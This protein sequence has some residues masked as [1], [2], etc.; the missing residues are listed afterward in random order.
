[1]KPITGTAQA[2][3]ELGAQAAPMKSVKSLI[4]Q[5]E[6]KSGK[7]AV[8][9]ASTGKASQSLAN[10]ESLK[11]VEEALLPPLPKTKPLVPIKKSTLA[12]AKETPSLFGSEASRLEAE[13]FSKAGG[14][15]FLGR[16]EISSIG[17]Q[18]KVPAGMGERPLA[19]TAKMGESRALEALNLEVSQSSS[20]D[21]LARFEQRH[22]KTA[23]QNMST[24]EFSQSL[25]NRADRKF[26]GNGPEVGKQ[27]HKYAKKLGERY[28]E[29]TGDKEHLMFEKR[30]IRNKKWE[31]GEGLKGSVVPDVYDPVT[32]EVFDYK[33][34]K[35]HLGTRQITNTTAVM[36]QLEG[37]TLAM[38]EVKPILKTE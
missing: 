13:F 15:S 29:M 3:E 1:M 26:L 38:T 9:N 37:K 36:P 30:F 27:K 6:Q 8:Q 10:R 2:T 12:K 35:A 33:F 16:Q 11:G 18:A 31:K 17:K 5:I 22:G 34:G 32:H 23:V 7:T 25:A 19:I 14:E 21:T 20:L 24:G 28:Q 4:A